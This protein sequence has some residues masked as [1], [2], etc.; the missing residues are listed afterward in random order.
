[1]FERIDVSSLLICTHIIKER[2][3]EK[4]VYG[5]E[6]IGN[7]QESSKVVDRV[8]MGQWERE[9]GFTVLSLQWRVMSQVLIF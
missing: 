3:E 1:M 4:L 5:I 8:E 2:K 7:C 9:Y 6:C